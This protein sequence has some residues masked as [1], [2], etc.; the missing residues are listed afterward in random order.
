MFVPSKPFQP[1]LM[2]VGKARGLPEWSTFLALI[3]NIRLGW[4]DL[5]GTN[6]L[7][8]YKNPLITAVKSFIVQAP[9]GAA[10]LRNIKTECPFIKP[11]L[12]WRRF[13]MIMP[14]T[15]TCDSHYCT[16]FGHLGR[17]D[18]DRI[19]SILTSRVAVTNGFAS[20]LRQCKWYIRHC[21]TLLG[22]LL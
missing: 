4:K 7:A 19:I 17:C 15:A 10:M 18:T 16:C 21:Q 5:P 20:N 13:C 11:C 22:P 14:A 2:F 1:S 9:G 6:T 8:Y 12:H 3:Q